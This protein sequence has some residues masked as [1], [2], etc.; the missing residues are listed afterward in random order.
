MRAYASMTLGGQ[1]AVPARGP[2]PES[3]LLSPVVS[4]S[5]MTCKLR[6]KSR[7]Y[8]RLAAALCGTAIAVCGSATPRSDATTLSI[9]V[10]TA[11]SQSLSG[12][13]R[14][15]TPSRAR[16]A[17]AARTRRPKTK[18]PESTVRAQLSFTAM[19]KYDYILGSG[20]YGGEPFSSLWAFSQA[21][22][23]T[24][25]MA[26]IPG[27]RARFAPEIHSRLIGLRSYLDTTNSGEPEGT[28][29]STLPAFDGV[30]APPAGPGGAKFYDD[31]AWVGIE[32]AR[33]YKMTHD[34]EA[35]GLAEQIMAFEMAGWQ[36]NPHQ[37][38]PGGIPFV[39]LTESTGRNTV[40][41]GP[42]AELAVQFYRITKNPEFL[43][44]AAK[45]YE[46]VRRCLL[47]PSGLYADSIHQRGEI[48]PTV[49]SY[50]QGTMIGAGTLLYQST[51]NSAFL[52]QA[53]QTARAAMTYF[54]PA[55]LRSELPFFP[56]IY[57]RNLMYLD[58]VTHDPPGPKLGQAYL[59]YTWT[60]LRLSNGLF[61]WGS[62]PLAQL[63]VQAA[64]TQIYGL[65]SSP[66]STYF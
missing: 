31:N 41:N 35:L 1:G 23:A 38:C 9:H 2:G 55:R 32:L 21:L 64:I 28:Y 37:T 63:L 50:N 15:L 39:N 43:H 51:G 7:P 66:P 25:T 52:F 4:A 16:S 53:R 8:A 24:V 13:T 20:L 45:V 10:G 29:T 30:V 62:P 49:W 47:L 42:T 40:A 59:D 17:I 19:Q 48:D 65:L 60:H 36:E 46:W 58:S 3:S 18:L 56:S 5:S 22:A 6:N 54:T 12:P 34:A 14:S 11:R 44:F 26:N 27:M 33:I 61:V 57:F